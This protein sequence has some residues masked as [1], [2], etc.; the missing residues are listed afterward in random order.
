MGRARVRNPLLLQDRTLVI[1]LLLGAT[2]YIVIGSWPG[3]MLLVASY[4]LSVAWAYRTAS[5]HPKRMYRVMG[6]VLFFMLGVFMTV[7]VAST[8]GIIR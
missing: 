7:Y 1:F 5:S 6:A 4:M 2:G 3:V 8:Q